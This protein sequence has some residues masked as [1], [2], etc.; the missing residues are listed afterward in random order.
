MDC[1]AE[2]S[3]QALVA[4]TKSS[5][6]GAIEMGQRPPEKCLHHVAVTSLVGVGEG[7]AGGRESSAQTAEPA[8]G[9][10]QGVADIVE[11]EGVG[12]L[13]E[14]QAGHMAP[15]G[16]GAGLLINPV[17][18]GEL[19][20]EMRGSELAELGEDG[21]LGM[22]WFLIFH[23][24]HPEWDGPPGTLKIT[25]VCGMAEDVINCFA[26]NGVGRIQ[27]LD[28]PPLESRNFQ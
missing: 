20:D 3:G 5:R 7:V 6:N 25:S 17:L 26:K 8:G 15:R 19:R 22:S 4:D 23:Q 10:A 21:Q 11:S 27:V 13:R 18:A 1:L 2:A 12:E 24:A 16:E 9:D 28:S 14:E